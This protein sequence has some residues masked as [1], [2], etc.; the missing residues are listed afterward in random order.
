LSAQRRADAA[1]I[2]GRLAD[3]PE[4]YARTI[5]GHDPWEMPCA[6]GRALSKPRARVAVKACHSSGKTHSA[7]EWVLWWVSRGGIAVTTAPT[8]TQVEKLLWGEITR[9]YHGA[10][11]PIG[12]RLL[13]TALQM[14][15]QNYAVGLSTNEG[16]NFQGW[17]GDVLI[18]LDEAPGVR[19][20]IYEA[21]EGIR[22]GGDV[23][24]L[25]LGNPTVAGGP[26]YEAFTRGR[27]GWVG[28]T[29]DAFATPNFHGL[30][31]EGVDPATLPDEEA[32]APLLAMTDEE[33]DHN[34]RPYLTTRRWVYE[35]WHEWGAASPLW[36]ARV[37]GR[38]PKQSEDSLLSLAWLE[39]AGIRDIA[40]GGGD[41]WVAGIDVAGP[42]EAETVLGIRH[43]PTLV[44]L[45]AWA[46]PDPRGD[47][48]AELAPF[49]DRLARV[50]V[51]SVGQGY[52]FARHLEDH[53]Y[54]R[55]VADV[56]VGEAASDTD[57][58]ANR[59]AELYWALRMRAQSGE[60]AGL[61]DETAVGQLAG[62]RYRHDARGRVVIEGKD[63]ARKRGVPSP[64][65]AEALML[66]YAPARPVRFVQPPPPA[67]A[68]RRRY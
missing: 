8:W 23:R 4:W 17:H 10:R 58:Y 22:A 65:R 12:G 5:L 25:L 28:F 1:A 54:A 59:K 18:V 55:R 61:T 42:G 30:Y 9:A 15:P 46:N 62:I 7:A 19:P 33:L 50:N 68:V 53:G 48:L 34:P 64:D 24:L 40:P 32:I 36:Q 49:K 47:V 6:I 16:V 26:F 31:P 56:N 3:D 13:Q 21:I 29:I 27:S 38:F 41:E 60:I 63:E 57:K 14:G 11:F 67:V 37:R 2:I 43:G 44:E 20:D 35:K 45:R 51:D 66:T 52:Y 39:A